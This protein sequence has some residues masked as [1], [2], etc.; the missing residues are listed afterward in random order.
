MCVLRCNWEMKLDLTGD[1]DWDDA[2]E[3]HDTR[4]HNVVNELTARDKGWRRQMRT[5]TLQ[6]EG[7]RSV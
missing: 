5:E 2:D 4:T 6:P 7:L 1:G 3:V